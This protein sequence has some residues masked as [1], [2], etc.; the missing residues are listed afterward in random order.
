MR[1]VLALGLVVW[2]TAACA[3]RDSAQIQ[4]WARYWVE[5][6]HDTLSADSGRLTSPDSA[7]LD[8][9]SSA[10]TADEW[11]RFWDEVEREQSGD[12]SA[13]ATP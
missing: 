3:D 1:L 6:R 10:W 4:A 11:L 13:V 9:L 2:A 8:S 5:R 12:S 7:L